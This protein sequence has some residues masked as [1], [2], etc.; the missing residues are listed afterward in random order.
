MSDALTVHRARCAAEREDWAREALALLREARE[1]QDK[2]SGEVSL[3]WL[4]RVDLLLEQAQ[5]ARET[6]D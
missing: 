6:V 3:E 5:G 1:A 4:T 2:A